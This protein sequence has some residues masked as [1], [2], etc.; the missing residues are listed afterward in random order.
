MLY[1]V[2]GQWDPRRE[3]GQ[4]G[5]CPVRRMRQQVEVK[6][7]PYTATG[8]EMRNTELRETVKKRSEI[9]RT[10]D[11]LSIA[12]IGIQRSKRHLKTH[13]NQKNIHSIYKNDFRRGN[14]W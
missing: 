2:R 12:I 4:G 13:T 6:D 9:C 1:K 14:R 3:L 5:R 11:F 10:K 7:P 8:T